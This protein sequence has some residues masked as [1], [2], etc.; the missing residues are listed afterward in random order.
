M[1]SIQTFCIKFHTLSDQQC[2]NFENRLTFDKVTERLKVETFLRHSVQIFIYGP[3]AL[4]RLITS[5]WRCKCRT[6]CCLEI[7]AI[8]LNFNPF[9][10]STVKWLH[11][12]VY[13]AIWSDPPFLI[14]DIRALWRSILSTRV[15]ECQ[16]IKRLG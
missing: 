2:K 4:S 9:K 16:K 11:F 5:V 13:R 14:F 1:R 10:S 6:E 8:E 3:T 7:N 12:E 15:P